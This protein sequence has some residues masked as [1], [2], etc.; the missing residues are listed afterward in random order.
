LTGTVAAGLG[1]LGQLGIAEIDEAANR[2]GP[3]ITAP[4]SHVPVWVVATDEELTIARHCRDH[5][6]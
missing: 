4:D 5:G 2:G 1:L 6:G 3:L